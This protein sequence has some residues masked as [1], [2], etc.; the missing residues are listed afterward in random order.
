MLIYLTYLKNMWSALK[1]ELRCLE[2]ANPDC[3]EKIEVKPL[4]S[5]SIGVVASAAIAIFVA[6]PLGVFLLTMITNAP[7][8][9]YILLYALPV[10]VATFMLFFVGRWIT[11]K[12][13]HDGVPFLFGEPRSEIVFSNGRHWLPPFATIREVDKRRG[14]EGVEDV[15]TY[16]KVPHPVRLRYTIRAEFSVKDSYKFLRLS[17]NSTFKEN[18]RHLGEQVLRLVTT[19]RTLDEALEAGSEIIKVLG[20]V[21]SHDPTPEIERERWGI[22]D[23]LDK[24]TKEW[25]VDIHNVFVS[26]PRL[27]EDVAADLQKAR[28]ELMQREAEKIGVANAI[29][30]MSVLQGKSMDVTLEIR[31]TDGT[32]E[33]KTMTFQLPKGLSPESAARFLQLEQGKGTLQINDNNITLTEESARALEKIGTVIIPLLMGKKEEENK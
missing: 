19:K 6:A 32:T 25:G 21:A 24:T 15:E 26:N 10:G 7:G 13:F 8:D 16:T 1:K 18:L 11:V 27:D 31:K 14:A 29:D 4:L 2:M 30:L 12:E 22:S 20:M 33:I 3:P 28:R 17:D 5:L 23:E 9:H